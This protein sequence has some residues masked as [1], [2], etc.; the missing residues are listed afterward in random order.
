VIGVI[1]QSVLSFCVVPNS[2]AGSL[3]TID[4]FGS[5]KQ[6]AIESQSTNA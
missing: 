4:E 2:A 6:A 3:T 1:P 5:L